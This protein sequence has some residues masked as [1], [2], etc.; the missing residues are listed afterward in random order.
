MSRAKIKSIT[1]AQIRN[2]AGPQVEVYDD[3]SFE[4]YRA[5]CK[6]G[7]CFEQPTQGL[8]GSGLH[9]LVASYGFCADR[10]DAKADLMGRLSGVCR[11]HAEPCEGHA[12]G[13][14]YWCNES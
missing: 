9:E 4:C 1:L 11:E 10:S 7:Y 5:T 3:P 13:D 6:P 2:A 14:C 12:R 8:E